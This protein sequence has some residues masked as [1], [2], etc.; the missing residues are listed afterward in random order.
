M[1]HR[2]QLAISR[3]TGDATLTTVAIDD[4][5]DF[6]QRIRELKESLPDIGP[7]DAKFATAACD[8]CGTRA[9]LDFEDPKLPRG[10]VAA[11]AGDF[12]PVCQALN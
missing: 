2:Q 4:D 1:R 6:A 11:E 10:W 7:T 8:G 3:Q 9:A 5:A 12:C